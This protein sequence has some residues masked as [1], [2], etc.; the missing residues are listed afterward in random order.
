[1]P[2][3]RYGPEGMPESLDPKDFVERRL[4]QQAKTRAQNIRHAIVTAAIAGLAALVVSLIFSAV[5]KDAEAT[6]RIAEGVSTCKQRKTA[7]RDSN[8]DKLVLQ[9]AL[10]EI[11]AILDTSAIN[12]RLAKSKAPFELK[13]LYEQAASQATD[14]AATFREKLAPLIVLNAGL[15]CKDDGTSVIAPPPDITPKVKFLLKAPK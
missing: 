14:A 1:M 10:N 3:Q 2:E 9:G 15:N 7:R 8:T 13:S 12:S 11:A 4:A 5:E 6:N